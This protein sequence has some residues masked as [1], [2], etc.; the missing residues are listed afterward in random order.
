MGAT[1]TI[2]R[3]F[4]SKDR[5]NED[6]TSAMPFGSRMFLKVRHRLVKQ[7]TRYREPLDPGLKLAATLRH[8][9]SGVK[10]SDKQYSWRVA[11]NTLSVVVRDVCHV[12]CGDY[13]DEVMTAPST[14]DEW[15]QLADGFLKNW[16]FPN[17]VAA[18]DGKHIAIRKPASSGSL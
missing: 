16:N 3:D 13:V 18:I 14:P 12:I 17:C 7:H 5:I 11:E 1:S 2:F 15:R 4:A 8:I 9:V 10:Y 6:T